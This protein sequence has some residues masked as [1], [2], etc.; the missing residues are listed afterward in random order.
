VC[1]AQSA[2]SEL[3]HVALAFLFDVSGSMGGDNRNRFDTKWLPVVAASEAIFS[4]TDA[5]AL[6]A[7]MTFFPAANA[8]TRCTEDAYLIPDVPQTPL[9]SPLFAQAINALNYTL[10]SNNW[11]SSTPTSFCLNKST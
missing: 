3:R 11:R 1:A 10:G 8:A 5:A 4:E 2:A 9:P 6:S 7:S